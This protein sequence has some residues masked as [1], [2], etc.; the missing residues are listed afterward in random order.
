LLDPK[1]FDVFINPQ[2]KSETLAK[3]YGWERCLSFPGLRCM[4]KRPQA[5]RVSYLDREGDEIEKDYEGF[6]ARVFLHE[7]DHVNGTTMTHWRVSEGNI[8]VDAEK[9]DEHQNLMTTV[10][11][12]KG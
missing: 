11:F 5:I 3:S 12:Y 4:V 9:T 8:D 10:E 6:Q 7:L 2:L 1:D